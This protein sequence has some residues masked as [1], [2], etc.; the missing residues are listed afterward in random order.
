M[1][2]TTH[3]SRRNPDGPYAAAQ[4]CIA[5]AARTKA[6]E[7]DLRAL[8]L[9]RIPPQPS[10]ALTACH[11]H[12]AGTVERGLKRVSCRGQSGARRNDRNWAPRTRAMVTSIAH[13]PASEAAARPALR[14]S[15]PGAG[16]H[17]Q[18]G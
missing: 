15:S 3:P 18:S 17:S 12:S 14:A 11:T 1:A 8:A 4:R 6:K 2:E 7:L 10:A 9:T 13:T 5:E 16:G